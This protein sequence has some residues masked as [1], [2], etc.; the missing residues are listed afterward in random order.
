MI[1]IIS[2]L[3]I[4][5]RENFVS[6][7]VRKSY[8]I[9]CGAAGIFLNLLL[10]F[11]KLSVGCISG[12]AAV[13]ADAVYNL[14][15]IGSSAVTLISF[16]ISGQ[17]K[18]KKYPFGKGRAEYIA[19]FILSIVLL[20]A[21]L[22]TAKAS[23]MKLITP[24]PVTFSV[25]AVVMLLISVLTKLYMSR[26]NKYYSERIDS[27]A[28]RAASVDCLLDSAATMIAA[29][30]VIGV[31]FTN[32]NIDAFGGLAVSLF[33]LFAGCKAAKDAV[34]AILGTAP[35]ECLCQKINSV[36]EQFPEILRT[37][38]LALHDYGSGHKI[39]TL[40]IF[41][42]GE[43]SF[44]ASNE[45]SDRLTEKIRSETGCEAVIKVIPESSIYTI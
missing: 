32:R 29:A 19:G 1:Y 7:R 22:Q 16:L 17:K 25:F 33:I 20:T 27:A 6:A 15:E 34:N 35:D 13:T 12:S 2:K 21:G 41:V 39:I 40:N 28:L 42:S 37:E 18:T 14:T 10:F 24:E 30:A 3:F 45:V 31:R 4:K 23:V 26:Y 9:L 5:D 38:N 36:L 11:L 8:G 43:L 44:A